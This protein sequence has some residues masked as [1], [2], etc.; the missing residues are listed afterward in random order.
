MPLLADEGFALRTH[1]YAESHRLCVFFTRRAGTLKAVAH[2][3]RSLKSRFGSGLEL[4]SEVRLSYREREGRELAHLES[5]DLVRSHFLAA[6]QPDTAAL[7]SYWAE[8]VIE[9]FPPHQANDAVYRLI[10][11]ALAAVDAGCDG[12]ALIRYFEVWILRLAG[13]FPNVAACAACRRAFA[14][15]EEILLAR[16]GAPECHA[17]ASG[18]GI[19]IS[20]ALRG[21]YGKILRLPP[22]DFAQR[23]LADDARRALG[24]V[25]GRFIRNILERE[26]KS[27]A[28]WLQLRPPTG[29]PPQ[30][31]S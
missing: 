24:E 7:L 15:D 13:F 14:D 25:N 17:C 2:G 27:Y 11:A 5:C 16:D 12:E 3:S 1:P 9:F 8:L 19:R 18:A 31:F 29:A 10:A 21:A 6:S 22:N 20:P 30:N 4:F 28:M 23:S 26:I